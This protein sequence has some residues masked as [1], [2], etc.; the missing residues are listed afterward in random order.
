MNANTLDSFILKLQFYIQLSLLIMGSAA[1][2]LSSERDKIHKGV[3]ASIYSL[4]V[5]SQ[6]PL[7]IHQLKKDYNEIEGG[8]IP[9]TEIG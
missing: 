8:R 6:E 5:S 3:I 1:E 4:L 7:T 2:S 9:I